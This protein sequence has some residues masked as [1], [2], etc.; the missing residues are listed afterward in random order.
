MR[1]S[2]PSDRATSWTLAPTCSHRLATS[3][4]KVTFIARKLLAAYLISSAVSSA[5]TTIGR[6][7]RYSG[8]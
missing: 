4:M 2:R 3:L 6:S 8:R 7:I 5:V 1:L